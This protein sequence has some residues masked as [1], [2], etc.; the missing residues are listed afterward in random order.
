MCVDNV[1]LIGHPTSRTWD[2]LG[3]LGI[4]W[5]IPR[6]IKGRSLGSPGV[7]EFIIPS[8]LGFTMD[9][10]R[11]WPRRWTRHRSGWVPLGFGCVYIDTC[12]TLEFTIGWQIFKVERKS[13][14][15]VVDGKIEVLGA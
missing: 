13:R 1:Q 14:S 6:S 9:V 8:Q 15:R 4:P 7:L 11:V 10:P 2:T 12:D 3:Y 5:D